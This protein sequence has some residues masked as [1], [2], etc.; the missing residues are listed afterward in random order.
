MK[1]KNINRCEDCYWYRW[2]DSVWGYCW[3][4]PPIVRLVGTIFKNIIPPRFWATKQD[5]PEV[6]YDEPACGGFA[7]KRN[8]LKIGG[9]E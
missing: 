2:E 8:F 6:F 1:N 3:R 7:H 9:D 5:R 4:F